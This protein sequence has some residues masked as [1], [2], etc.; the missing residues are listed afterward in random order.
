MSAAEHERR[1][2]CVARLVADVDADLADYRRLIAVLDAL[3]RALAGE[4]LDALARTHEAALQLVSRLRTRA[5][6]RVQCLEQAFGATSAN[7]MAPVMR[8][9]ATDAPEAYETFAS[10][11]TSLQTIAARCKTINARNL[12]DIG[13]RLQAL[14][15][16]LSPMAATYAPQR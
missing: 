3:H 5:R 15:V 13:A 7:T 1:R 4:H 11:W 9:L 12:R 8:W 10:R 16:V 2:A 6:R 14:D